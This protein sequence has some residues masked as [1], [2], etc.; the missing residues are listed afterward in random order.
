MGVVAMSLLGKQMKAIML[1]LR[2]LDT[3]ITTEQII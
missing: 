1:L 2:F 3:L